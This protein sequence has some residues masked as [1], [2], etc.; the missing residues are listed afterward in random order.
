MQDNQQCTAIFLL[1]PDGFD[2]FLPILDFKIYSNKQIP[3]KNQK[4]GWI[5]LMFTSAVYAVS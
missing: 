1:F 4:H 3:I 5:V 2:M